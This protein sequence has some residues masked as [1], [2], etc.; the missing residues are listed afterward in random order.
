M[1]KEN[2]NF[3]FPGYNDATYFITP[4]ATFTCPH[5]KASSMQASTDSVFI[6]PYPEHRKL[7]PQKSTDSAKLDFSNFNFILMQL[8][9]F[10][11]GAMAIVLNLKQYQDCSLIKRAKSL[12]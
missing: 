12:A 4:K 11:D 2:I 9:T 7:G 5:H 3:Q 10:S 1:K 6:Q 8:L